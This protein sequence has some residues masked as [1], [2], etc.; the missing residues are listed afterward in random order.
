MNCG[1]VSSTTCAMGCCSTCTLLITLAFTG[2]WIALVAVGATNGSLPHHVRTGMVSAGGVCLGW[3]LVY[4]IVALAQS[5]CG[6]NSVDRGF[7]AWLGLRREKSWCFVVTS[8]CLGIAS[9]IVSIVLISIGG[10]RN[11]SAMW[12]AGVANLGYT[13]VTGTIFL[14]LTCCY[15]I[16][17]HSVGH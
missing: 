5:M 8:I 6:S 17:E 9:V 11:S 15:C 3:S 13:L 14:F 4:L 12:A 16:T 1:Q 7:A 2:G 10:T